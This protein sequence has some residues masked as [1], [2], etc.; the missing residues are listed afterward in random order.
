MWEN[1][2]KMLLSPC[3]AVFPF[4]VQENMQIAFLWMPCHILVKVLWGS[5]HLAEL[6]LVPA[7]RVWL[8]LLIETDFVIRDTQV[9]CCLRS[10][11]VSGHSNPF[12][13]RCNSAKAHTH[14]HTHARAPTEEAGSAGLL[15]DCSWMHRLER[16][17]PQ[18]ALP[19][20][21]C[22][23]LSFWRRWWFGA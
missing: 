23:C 5:M 4:P 14:T 17:P 20:S 1:S 19:P 13:F 21:G 15:P 16:P 6:S 11:W 22:F 12:G 18:S 2:R 10:S 8:F 3:F 9:W 7:W